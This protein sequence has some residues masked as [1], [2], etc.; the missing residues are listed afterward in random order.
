MSARCFVLSWWILLHLL[1]L[2][3]VGI[4]GFLNSHLF[5]SSVI[6]ISLGYY[7]ALH[8]LL[9]HLVL[10]RRSKFLFN[11][12][13]YRASISSFLSKVKLVALTAI[14]SLSLSP[15]SSSLFSVS[16]SANIPLADFPSINS[17]VLTKF[18]VC[19]LL[20][21]ITMLPTRGGLIIYF[22]LFLCLCAQSSL[23][24][25]QTINEPNNLNSYSQFFLLLAS[26]K[27]CFIY[28]VFGSRSVCGS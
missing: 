2:T 24:H 13:T 5:F 18:S 25:L 21:V 10:D 16:A 19:V 20:R 8:W 12:N 26:I 6:L 11:C 28:V 15:S 9:N 3:I 17:Y 27:L 23:F 4:S 7:R 1:Q 22:C 14:I